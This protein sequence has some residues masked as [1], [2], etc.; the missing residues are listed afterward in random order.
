MYV[1]ANVAI[2]LCTSDV[3]II[4]FVVAFL[5]SLD[6]LIVPEFPDDIQDT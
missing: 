5:R 2:K 4:V 6:F 1:Q 3:H